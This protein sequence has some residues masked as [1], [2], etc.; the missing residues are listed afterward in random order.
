MQVLEKGSIQAEGL[1]SAEALRPVR[2]EEEQEGS[3]ASMADGGLEAVQLETGVALKTG[4]YC[5]SDGSFGCLEQSW[6]II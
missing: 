4:F 5:G 3:L 1:A 2:F 6:V